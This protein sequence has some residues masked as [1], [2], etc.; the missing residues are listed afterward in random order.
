MAETTTPSAAM[1]ES[2][3]RLILGGLADLPSRK[4]HR[5][6]LEAVAKT[7]FK[8][9]MILA[10]AVNHVPADATEEAEDDIWT[11]QVKMTRYDEQLERCTNMYKMDD[12]GFQCRVNTFGNMQ[13]IGAIVEAREDSLYTHWMIRLICRPEK[14][15]MHLEKYTIYHNEKEEYRILIGEVTEVAHRRLPFQ[16][17]LIMTAKP[18]SRHQLFRLL[19]RLERDGGYVSADYLCPCKNWMLYVRVNVWPVRARECVMVHGISWRRCLSRFLE[20]QG[21]PGK[22]KAP[23]RIGGL[24]ERFANEVT[25]RAWLLQDKAMQRIIDAHPMPTDEEG[26]IRHLEEKLL[27]VMSGVVTEDTTYT[28]KEVM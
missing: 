11:R 16:D 4:R 28:F 18:T 25:E 17:C 8:A 2:D 15:Q 6:Q 26:D 20:R 12:P 1:T 24:D 3:G 7:L 10:Q 22:F 23:Q 19:R 13:R 5:V 21:V 27:A 14:M 9:Q